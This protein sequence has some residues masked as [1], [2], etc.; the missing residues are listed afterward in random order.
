[1][2]VTLFRLAFAGI[3][4]RLLASALTITLCSAAAATV[5][6]ALE[7]GAT[8][9]DPWQ[10]TFDAAHGAHVLVF[11][12]S[13]SD[14]RRIAS[15]PGVSER[16]APMPIAHATMG[17][18][19]Q[20]ATDVMLAGLQGEPS[21]N[22][23]VRTEGEGV[24]PGG[25]V[26]ERSLAN[27]LGLRVGSVLTVKGSAPQA[28][29]LPVVG[30]AILPSQPR[31][32]RRN[33]GLAWV[34]RG[35]L[36][37]IDADHG[38]WSWAQ[39]LRL[40]D[41]SAAGSFVDRAAQSFSASA[42]Q[43]GELALT[44]WQ[45]QRADALME[46]QPISV[47]LTMF[48]VLL[49]VV[50]FAIVTILTGARAGAQHREIALLKAIGLTPHQVSS[51]F[52]IESG[53]LGFVA[54]GIG[55]ALGAL[56]APTLVAPGADTLLVPPSVA[57]S[58]VHVLLAS[59]V[60]LPVLM[61]G[62]YL[63]TRR[64]TR[65]SVLAALDAGVVSPRPRSRTGRLV[66]RTP[67]PLPVRFGLADLLAR[68]MRALWLGS[69]IAVTSAVIVATL[70]MQEAID[71]PVAGGV[72]D[73][74]SELPV[75]V[76]TLDTVL[77]LIAGTALMAVALLSVRER[78]RDI[79]VLK[80]IGLTPGQI[81][82]SLV[83]AFT[84]LAVLAA[85]LSVPLGLGFY[86]LI[87]SVTSGSTAGVVFASWWSLILVPVV[88]AVIVALATGVPISLASRIRVSDALRYE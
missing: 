23:P 86:L 61:L 70:S 10:R 65:F 48:T 31:Y 63:S 52:V 87:Y 16:A 80:A 77:V 54:I 34:T 19:G 1:M 2:T 73:V 18:P 82:S 59:C 72:S 68:R 13:A 38:D 3:R 64:T 79:R 84:A 41:P 35:T 7:V 76:Y 58:P 21:V 49:L 71:V 25:I 55:F 22:A 69:A 45:E 44:T 27:A 40:K 56:L 36:E 15:M 51:V 9:R 20:A 85:C 81:S 46:S 26:L 33:P 24:R 47:L 28:I 4:S 12:K 66:A 78:V 29:E 17:W 57:A 60:V 11:T 74:P 8:G 43:S 62:A 6:L 14:A 53:M 83:G 5:V 75:L 67:L 32:P 42:G 30:T 50:V 39:A 88:V 37:Q